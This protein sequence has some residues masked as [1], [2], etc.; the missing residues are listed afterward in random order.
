MVA[1]PREQPLG[2][3][4]QG[5]APWFHGWRAYRGPVLAALM[6]LALSL[7]AFFTLYGWERTRAHF[8]LMTAAE[9]IG[10]I[11]NRC[12]HFQVDVLYALAALFNTFPAQ[13]DYPA[14]RTFARPLTEH[15][16]ALLALH[17]IPRVT[18]AERP[19][20]E[21]RVQ[22]VFPG[23]Q[24]T[25]PAQQGG[26]EREGPR[27]AY[28]PILYLEPLE[29]YR[30]AL[31]FDVASRPG[32]RSALEQARDT[33]Q[34]VIWTLR[35]LAPYPVGPPTQ[36]IFYPIYVPGAAVD[37]VTA[38][39]Q[40]LRGFVASALR[41]SGIMEEALRAA[42][43]PAVDVYF[44]QTVPDGHREL[45]Y[46][47]H[48]PT[49]PHGLQAA[50]NR[51]PATAP[52]VS[53]NFD[54]AGYTWSVSVT[55]AGGVDPALR[56][57]QP[58]GGLGLG[59]LGTLLLL[60]YWQVLRVHAARIEQLAGALRASETQLRQQAEQLAEAD[61]RK[62][63]FLAELSHELRNP[64]APISNA[65]EVLRRQPDPVPAPI[66]HWVEGVI[67]RQVEQLTHLVNDLLDVARITRGLIELKKRQ[68]ELSEMVSRAIDSARP[69]I[70]VR[71]HTLTV[72]LP[73]EPVHLNADP[74]RLVQ[75]L[76]N[77]LDNA[78]KYTPEHGRITLS[79]AREGQEAVVRVQ[80]TGK[81]IPPEQL[82]HVFELSYR[83][84]HAG[85]REGEGLGL[86]LSVARRL[87]EMHGGSIQAES[88]GLD[89]G[90][91]F[92]VRLPLNGE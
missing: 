6:G 4:P 83:V 79:A 66:R 55:P 58:W 40:A 2:L 53:N 59:L 63:E 78:A 67:G 82:A 19:G 29:A 20:F 10:A 71:H 27:E 89:R 43:N 54:V 14:F 7:L 68:V 51:P 57:W 15:C 35:A 74:T 11:V 60:W 36:M 9:D 31:G 61:R 50:L 49:A 21:A 87:I 24:I 23:F 38:R 65:I 88:A 39:G 64:L 72:K 48:A 77:L 92:T 45:L 16:E 26:V 1:W 8:R 62:D 46:A 80:D 25:A 22:Q 84:E 3:T 5:T 75:V 44:Y 17:W 34:I 33:G 91:T 86:G 70:E 37:T 28:F 56:S 12:A 18:E 32:R 30:E 85:T 69:M 81:G 41:I 52:V 73:P 13:I 47:Y 76:G 90:S 42:G